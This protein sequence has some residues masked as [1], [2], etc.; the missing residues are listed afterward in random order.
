MDYI[1][2][3]LLFKIRKVLRYVR[4]YGPSRTRVKVQGQLHMK[5]AYD[6]VPESTRRFKELQSVG[7]LGCG[8]YAFSNIA[9]YLNKERGNV[10]RACM[11]KEGGRAASLAEQYDVPLHTNDAAEVISNEGCNLLYIAS[12]HASHA[13][14]AIQGLELGKHVYIEKPHVVSYDQLDRLMAAMKK[15]RGKVF[16]GFN[17]PGSRFGRIILEQ[18]AAQT[19]AG[20]YNWFVAG[21][22]IEP[23][24]WYFQDAEGGRVLGNLCHWTDFVLRMAG[25]NF[26][27]RITPTRGTK[28]DADIAVTY[29]F[30]DETIAVITFSAKGHTFE[31]VREHLSAHRGNCLMTMSDYETLTVEVVHQKT[32]YRNLFRD[33]GHSRNIVQAYDSV[34]QDKPYDRAAEHQYIANSAWLFLKT[35]E[36][37]ETNQ[38]LV[39]DPYPL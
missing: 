15:S 20:M 10:I 1:R 12:N 31:G 24:H 13:E 23:D 4:I 5:K 14:Y 37:L 6:T 22:A 30:K 28:S 26:P 36:A 3:P 17:R 18:L 8:N 19:G 32:T 35:R 2:Q 38:T 25:D 34:A 9:Y 39:V 7:L 11:D 27:V 16:L 29:T 33:H 21:H